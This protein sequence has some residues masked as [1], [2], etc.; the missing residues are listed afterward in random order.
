MVLGNLA[1]GMFAMTAFQHDHVHPTDVGQRMLAAVM[2]PVIKR[3]LPNTPTLPRT[4]TRRSRSGRTI[5]GL[6]PRA[7]AGLWTHA[8]DKLGRR[9][10][11]SRIAHHE[12]DNRQR[13]AG[14]RRLDA[15]RGGR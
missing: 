14:A 15:P 7:G 5:Y 9:R 3:L 13:V 10:V 8:T 12:R 4:W 2:K 1:H 11:R 6:H